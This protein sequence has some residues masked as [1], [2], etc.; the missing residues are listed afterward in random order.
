MSKYILRL[1][2]A[3]EYM[4]KPN[5]ERIEAICEKYDIKPLVGI[6]PKCTD[7][8][9]T[10]F[11][12]NEYFWKK[13]LN[14]WLKKGWEVALHGYNHVFHTKSGGINPVN[15]RSEFAG[16]SYEIQKEKIELGYLELKE[17]GL[18]PKVFFAPA[19]TYDKNTIAA[20]KEVTPIRII[21]DTPATNIYSKYGIT[22]VPQISGRVRKLPF[23]YVTFCYHPNNMVEKDFVELERFI[24]VNNKKFIS[25]PVHET[26]KKRTIL[27]IL[28][29][30]MYYFKHR[31]KKC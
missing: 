20:L 23:K 1:D 7:K 16:L 13:M 22:F 28:I 24:K 14:R 5:W 12:Y 10:K 11:D 30:K 8:D 31:R 29:S 26:S 17:K 2:D 3:C 4:N 15:Y 19:H 18:M 6:I 27:S 25:F 21:S 9:I